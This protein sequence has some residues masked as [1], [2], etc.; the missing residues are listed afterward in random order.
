MKCMAPLILALA[1]LPS[2]RTSAAPDATS[3][4]ADVVALRIDS[5]DPADR[6]VVDG[7]PIAAMDAPTLDVERTNTDAAPHRL[8]GDSGDRPGADDAGVVTVRPEVG[9]SDVG[10]P[11]DVPV[12]DDRPDMP[13]DVRPDVLT[14]RD[15]ESACVTGDS[16]PR[17]VSF[18]WDADHC[19]GCEN[20]C[21]GRVCIEG[22]CG[23]EGPPGTYGCPST[24]E[25]RRLH[26]CIGVV[27]AQILTDPEHCGNCGHRCAQDDI[28]VNGLCQ[29]R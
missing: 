27:R 11:G 17:C 3:G 14:C 29:G 9:T 4:A 7:G 28:C 23:A 8:D 18:R 12:T 2:C 19:G 21:C 1:S 20:R 22:H 26:Q 15:G 10:H 24:E 6:D 13:A 16:A 5:S 25:Y